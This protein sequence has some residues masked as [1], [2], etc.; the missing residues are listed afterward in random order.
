MS[1]SLTKLEIVRQQ[2]YIEMG[3][4]LLELMCFE[5]AMD[6]DKFKVTPMHANCLKVGI[7]AMVI[8]TMITTAV[9]AAR[10]E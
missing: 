9:A 6:S 3:D 8:D 7:E 10:A 5:E 2:L 1:K 4:D